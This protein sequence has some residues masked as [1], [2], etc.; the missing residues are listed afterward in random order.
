MNGKYRI[1]VVDD[2]EENRGA[3]AELLRAKGYV[4]EEARNG[5]EA[6]AKKDDFP[7]H[8]FLLDVVM[9]EMN[10]LELLEDS[11]LRIILMK[12]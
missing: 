8:L 6:I 9:P 7:A 4:V 12:Q 2:S 1:M 10:G 5:R 11:I 3:V